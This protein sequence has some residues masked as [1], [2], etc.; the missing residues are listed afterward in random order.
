MGH[1]SFISYIHA[2]SMRLSHVTCY[3]KQLG[4]YIHTYIHTIYLHTYITIETP[5]H[6]D[7]DVDF[8]YLKKKRKHGQGS[9]FSP[10]I[11][12]GV[13]KQRYYA[14]AVV[15]ITDRHENMEVADGMAVFIKKGEPG[16]EL[17]VHTDLFISKVYSKYSML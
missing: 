8:T 17:T 1:C 4:S 13:V 2:K 11:T 14:R 16:S 6:T 12:V 10:A 5:L 9:H 7:V 15:L 3:T